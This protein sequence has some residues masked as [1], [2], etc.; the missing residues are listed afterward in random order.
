MSNAEIDTFCSPKYFQSL[1][2]VTYVLVP[3]ND[4]FTVKIVN[5]EQFLR[6]A[7]HDML[8]TRSMLYLQLT[9]TSWIT[10]LLQYTS[11][12]TSLTRSPSPHANQA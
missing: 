12:L 9:S 11:G 1:T 8:Q 7:T 5:V 10:A 3:V 6:N 2:V 4:S